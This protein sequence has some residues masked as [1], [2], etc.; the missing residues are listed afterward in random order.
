[1]LR[2]PA[3]GRLR[4]QDGPDRLGPGPLRADQV[5]LHGVRRPAERAR[6][7]VHPHFGAAGRQRGPALRAHVVVR[8]LA[9]AQPPRV[10][11]HRQRRELHRPPLPGAV[12]HPEPDAREPRLPRLRGDGGQR[13]PPSRRRAAGPALGDD[14]THRLHPHRRRRGG[15]GVPAHGGGDH[16]DRRHRGVP[17]RHPVPAQQPA[18]RVHDIEATVCWMDE[19]S[20]AGRGPHLPAQAQHPDGAGHGRVAAVPARR[21]RPAPRRGRRRRSS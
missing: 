19:R 11:L 15:R 7:H 13:R 20:A 1:M 4:Q 2:R 9:A 18:D 6:H 14:V 10:G 8:R 21:Q 16:A 3:H 17:G 12:R 5:G